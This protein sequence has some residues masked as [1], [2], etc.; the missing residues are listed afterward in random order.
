[1]LALSRVLLQSVVVWYLLSG[2]VCAQAAPFL[3]FEIVDV[4]DHSPPA[5]TQG[6]VQTGE[7]VFETSGLYG[8]SYI[9]HYHAENGE[10]QR[11]VDLPD[12]LFAEGLTWMD[13]TLYMLTWK[14]GK[15]WVLDPDS[16]E[17]KQKIRYQGEGWGLTNNGSQLIMSNGTDQLLFRCKDSFEVERALTVREGDRTWRNLNELVY[18]EGLIWA[19]VWLSPII[20]AIDPA[21]G[22]VVGKVDF[23]ALV[24]KNSTDP[25]HTVL[26]GIA[27]DSTTASY[28]I[29]GKHWPNR[30][31]VRFIWPEKSQEQTLP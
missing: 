28:W 11:R 20:L 14:A 27:F 6:L 16:L 25:T 18:A 26:N 1:M 19:N 23:S 15:M 7:W 13:D 8:Q 4:K 5:F 21:S 12:H 2:L 17:V 22:R 24:K 29:T 3:A 31:R 9:V 30:Y 10:L